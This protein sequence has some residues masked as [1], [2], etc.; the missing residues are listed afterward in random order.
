MAEPASQIG[1]ANVRPML[2]FISELY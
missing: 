2:T 1:I